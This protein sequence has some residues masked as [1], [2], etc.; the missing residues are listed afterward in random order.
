M[1]DGKDSVEEQL[2]RPL[3]V[4][5]CYISRYLACVLSTKDAC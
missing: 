5:H 1:V 4:S 2:P 3:D